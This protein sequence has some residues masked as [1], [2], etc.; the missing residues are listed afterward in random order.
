MQG[1]LA[2]LE[3]KPVVLAMAPPPAEQGDAVH[4]SCS[5]PSFGAQE[6]LGLLGV[7]GQ[8]SVELCWQE[9]QELMKLLLLEE[10]P[11]LVIPMDRL[12]DFLVGY[13]IVLYRRRKC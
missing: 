11:A 12:V 3:S 2:H 7:E 4:M 10:R 13:K 9:L 1:R 6:L 5:Y 8:Y